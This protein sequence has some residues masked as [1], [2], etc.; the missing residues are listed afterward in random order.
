MASLSFSVSASGEK[1]ASFIKTESHA[2]RRSGPRG[3]GA[4][5]RLEE[6]RV[7]MRKEIR[8]KIEKIASDDLDFASE[9]FAAADDAAK[10][11]VQKLREDIEARAAKTIPAWLA[12]HDEADEGEGGRPEGGQ[13]PPR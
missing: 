12:G 4:R 5:K 3:G 1:R 7:A 6:K 11:L 8:G 13:E 2:A 9:A 10:T